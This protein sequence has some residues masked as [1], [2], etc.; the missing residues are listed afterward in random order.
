MKPAMKIL[1]LAAYLTLVSPNGV[2]ATDH[3]DDYWLAVTPYVEEWHQV[4]RRRDDEDEAETPSDK[5]GFAS[6]KDNDDWDAT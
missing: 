6:G 3:R 4:E 1:A 2:K 5:G